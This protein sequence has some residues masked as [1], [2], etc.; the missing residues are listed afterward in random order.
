[1]SMN[2][3]RQKDDWLHYLR[4]LPR[5]R[6]TDLWLRISVD[7]VSTILQEGAYVFARPWHL[8]VQNVFRPGLP[9]EWSQLA[10]ARDHP[11]LTREIVIESTQTIAS[12][13][14]EIRD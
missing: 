9:G 12:R 7:G 8:F 14:I 10:V 2:V 4:S 5:T 3:L 1:M 13:R 11:A 6:P